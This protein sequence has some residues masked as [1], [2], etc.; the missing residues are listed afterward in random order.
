MALTV[1]FRPR[2]SLAKMFVIVSTADF[3]A[4]ERVTGQGEADRWSRN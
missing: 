3:V 4:V 2:N 1:M